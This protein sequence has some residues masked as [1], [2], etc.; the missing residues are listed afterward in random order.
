MTSNLYPITNDPII[1]KFMRT[2]FWDQL[3]STP[4]LL[5]IYVGGS[6]LYGAPYATEDS[7][8]DIQVIV[9]ADQYITPTKFIAI[10][11]KLLHWTIQ[12]LD[13]YLYSEQYSKD[14]NRIWAIHAG[15][16]KLDCFTEACLLYTSPGANSVIAKLLQ[17]RNK[18]QKVHFYYYVTKL[19]RVINRSTP[20]AA[21]AEVYR[22]PKAFYHVFA[23]Y[24][25]LTGIGN[26]EWIVSIKHNKLLTPGDIVE[27]LR[28]FDQIEQWCLQNKDKI[29]SLETYLY[30]AFIE[31]YK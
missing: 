8:Y 6:R 26:T 5:F 10:D 29:Y 1:Q 22:Y 14:L 12:S 23:A 2:F 19:A 11:G 31:L 30:D 4:D 7:D 9:K 17:E 18:I 27:V 3:L 25:S 15:A 20:K 21:L 13:Y 28:Q 16:V 24:R